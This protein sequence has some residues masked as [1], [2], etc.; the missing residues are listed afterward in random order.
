MSARKSD[1][2]AAAMAQVRII[3]VD[4]HPLVRKGL[5]E[6]L[7][8]EPDFLVCGEA[9]DRLGALQMAV[10][11]KPDLAIGDLGL[12][13][14][15]GLDLIKDLR[16]RFPNL[17]VLVVSICDELLF[18]ERALRAGACGYV[19][20]EEAAT[21]VVEAARRVLRGDVYVSRRV[22]AQMAS[23]LAGR[24]HTGLVPALHTLSD[25]ELEIFEMLGKGFSRQQVAGRL[26]LGVNTVETYRAR[27]K[28]KL[29]LRDAVE[30]LQYAIRSGRCDL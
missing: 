19:G 1:R 14:S 3:L 9:E 16:A 18:A 5:A 13:N 21:C 7:Q 17:L 2:P 12:K 29:H 4:D 30:L 11:T 10:A 28:Q 26:H 6:V 20:K 25:R 22:T 27:I 8:C 24:P 23:R 15:Y